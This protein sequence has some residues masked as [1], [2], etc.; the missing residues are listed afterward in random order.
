MNEKNRPDPYLKGLIV[1]EGCIQPAISLHI[2]DLNRK[3]QVF[4][5][6]LGAINFFIKSPV[7]IE[8]ENPYQH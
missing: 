4:G 1:D 5:L 8:F 2:H 7:R 6:K 3:G